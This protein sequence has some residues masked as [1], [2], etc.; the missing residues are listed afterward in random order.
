MARLVAEAPDLVRAWYRLRDVTLVGRLHAIEHHSIATAANQAEILGVRPAERH[1]RAGGFSAPKMPTLQ[2]II[3]PQLLGK[4][5]AFVCHAFEHI[6][7]RQWIAAGGQFVVAAFSGEDRPRAAHAR[8]I[9]RRAI[10]LLPVSVV[11]VASPARALRQFAANG[12]VDHFKR[13]DYQRVVGGR[14]FRA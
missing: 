4:H 1:G 2:V 12:P 7:V 5:T 6:D 10:I 8:A 11:I 3:I 14:E 9:E 13:I